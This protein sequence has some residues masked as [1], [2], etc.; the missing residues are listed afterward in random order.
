MSNKSVCMKLC[1]STSEGKRV[2]TCFELPH[3]KTGPKNPAIWR[4]TKHDESYVDK[5]KSWNFA[6]LANQCIKLLC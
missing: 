2:S 5:F 1:S 3:P 6:Y 4:G